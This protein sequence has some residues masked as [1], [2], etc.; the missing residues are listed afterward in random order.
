MARRARR[1]E[2]VL[3]QVVHLAKQVG[4]DSRLTKMRWKDKNNLTVLKES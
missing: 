3:V 2:S 4:T 1:L